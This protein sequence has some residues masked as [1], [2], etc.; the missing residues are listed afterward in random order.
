MGY[1]PC[2]TSGGGGGMSEMVGS[3]KKLT[4]YLSVT[5]A[6]E[7]GVECGWEENKVLD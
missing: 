3:V 4:E 6:R 5:C 7:K 2:L 1:L